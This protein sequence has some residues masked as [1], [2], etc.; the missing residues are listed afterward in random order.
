M[1]A[2]VGLDAEILYVPEPDAS[3]QTPVLPTFDDSTETWTTDSTALGTT[4]DWFIFPE[5]NEFSISISV[6]IADHKVFVSSP[7]G[8]WTEKARLYMDWSGSMSGY[9][10]NAD[11]TIFNQ[12]KLGNSLWA[13]F[14]DSKSNDIPTGDNAPT[15]YWLGKIVLGTIDRTTPNEDFATLDVDFEGDGELYRSETP[16]TF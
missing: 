12:M 10:D 3:G 7:T 11:D 5:R 14:V 4:Y 13:L 15:N 16:T 9:L 2:I 8:A 1:S 6:D